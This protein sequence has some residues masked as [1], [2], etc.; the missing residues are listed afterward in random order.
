MNLR[1]KIRFP[2]NRDDGLGACSDCVEGWFIRQ[3]LKATNQFFGEKP[4]DRILVLIL[5]L[6]IENRLLNFLYFKL[7][8]IFLKRK[9]IK[10]SKGR[11]KFMILRSSRIRKCLEGFERREI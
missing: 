8:K 11:G 2:N 5:G 4:R 7:F 9:K 1:R 6:F 10:R 3:Q